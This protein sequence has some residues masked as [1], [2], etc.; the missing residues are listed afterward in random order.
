MVVSRA[1]M[2]ERSALVTALIVE[3]PMCVRCI[4]ERC[5]LAGR[6]V[7]QILA[8]LDPLVTHRFTKAR[9]RACGNDDEVYSVERPVD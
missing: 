2:P 6:S 3:R 1:V 9:C 7:K 5:G 8:R 4:A